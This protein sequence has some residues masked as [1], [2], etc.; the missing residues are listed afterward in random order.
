MDG[1]IFLPFFF[2]YNPAMAKQKPSRQKDRKKRKSG[3]ISGF[4]TLNQV[5]GVPKPRE[6]HSS[7]PVESPGTIME[8]RP[9]CPYCGETIENI[10]SA[11]VASDGSYIHFDCVLSRITDEVKPKE[12]EC[13]S[14]VGSGSFALIG[15]DEEGHSV[16]IRKIPFES[17]EHTKEMKAY[18]SS[19]R[20]A[21]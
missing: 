6:H 3:G 12:G 19:L 7:I 20:S 4:S 5:A 18:I 10:A 21:Q 13:V 14:Y 8:P 2:W 15:K 11:L 17:P 16:I 1:R 9:V